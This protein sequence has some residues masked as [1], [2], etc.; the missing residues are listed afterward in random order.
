MDYEDYE[1]DNDGYAQRD[2]GTWYLTPRGL[3]QWMDEEG[4]LSG[5]MQR[6]GADTFIEAGCGQAIV[7]AYIAATEAMERELERIG[8]IL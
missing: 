1:P 6:N 7:H 3:A 4:G 2:D 8:A 5:L